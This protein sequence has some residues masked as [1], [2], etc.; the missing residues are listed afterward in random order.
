[1][2]MYSDVSGDY[3][4]LKSKGVMLEN[5]KSV[6]RRFCPLSDLYVCFFSV[7]FLNGY[8]NSIVNSFI[9]CGHWSVS[10]NGVPSIF[11]SLPL[12]LISSLS[13]KSLNL[14]MTGRGDFEHNPGL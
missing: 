12:L 13:L 8:R 9:P 4:R 6:Q 1:M 3:S 2:Q 5:R 11:I 14:A 7:L 10:L